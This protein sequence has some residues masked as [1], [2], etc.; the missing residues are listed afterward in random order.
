MKVDEVYFTDLEDLSLY[1]AKEENFYVHFEI[2][3]G[4]DKYLRQ[5][6]T[7]CSLCDTWRGIV[8][9]IDKNRFSFSK[10]FF[11]RELVEQLLVS[12]KH[13]GMMGVPLCVPRTL[14]G[15]YLYMRFIENR[16]PQNSQSK[17]KSPTTN[18]FLPLCEGCIDK[19][20]CSGTDGFS[21]DDFHPKIKKTTTTLRLDA[22]EPFDKEL[23]FLN[24][25]HAFY[26]NYCLQNKSS[27]GY[28]T[29]Y[30]VSN[31]DFDSVHS[32]ADR[33]VY[34]CDYMGADE[35]TNEFEFL[36][37]H[38]IHSR[39]VD[40]LESVASVEKTS[41]IAY[42]L[43]QKGDVYRESF[44]MFVTK[45]YGNKV[46]ADFQITFQYPKSPD[47]VF[48]GLGMDV[49]DDL[50]QGYKLY[51]HSTKS[52]LRSYLMPFDLDI[53]KLTHNS[54]YLVWRL[55]KEQQFISYKIELLFV[56]EDLQWFK[57]ILP[58]YD[59]Y[60]KTLKPTSLYNFAIEIVNNKI[61]K[62]NIYHQNFLARSEHY[63]I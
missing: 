22:M 32:Y 58:N 33:F 48:I 21:F 25:M 44:Y 23:V 5:I 63:G 2:D 9:H 18:I 61:S 8:F 34:G 43:A 39:Y 42:S 38:T 49:I 53:S 30:Y 20:S 55:D 6:V 35:Y 11:L 4:N 40:L 26:L 10:L 17:P 37:E 19:H 46:L 13:I 50:T 31:I 15:G 1:H 59:H 3:R 41:Q 57:H 62:I 14:L 7:I 36:R 54:H 47:M 60:V 45:Q 28:R 56:Y 24:K 12:G 29:V 51:F 52:F 27:V 16:I